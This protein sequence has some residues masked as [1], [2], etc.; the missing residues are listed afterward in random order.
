MNAGR[1]RLRDAVRQLEMGS[2]ANQ[3]KVWVRITSVRWRSSPRPPYVGFEPAASSPKGRIMLLNSSPANASSY[4]PFD[5]AAFSQ[6]SA[7]LLPARPRLRL[8]PESSRPAVQ[9]HPADIVTRRV[10]TTDCMAAEVVQATRREKIEFRFRAPFHLLVIYDQGSRNSGDTYVEGLPRSTLRDLARKLVFVPAGQEYREWQ[11][12][13]VR[14]RVM[15]IYFDPARMPLVDSASASL[16]PRLFFEDATL[17]N[18]ALKLKSEIE[19]G[20][21]DSSSYFDALAGV[22][23]HELLRLDTG[24]ARPRTLD[25]GGLAAW[26]KRTVAAYI[27]EHLA[28]PIPLATL[29]QLAGLSAYHFCRTFKQS[30]GMPPHRYHTS[31]RIEHAKTLLAKSPSTVTD[32]GLSVGFSDTSSFTGVFRK[33]T[34]LTPTAFRRSLE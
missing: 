32:I 19:N 4:D 8:A 20:G 25:H 15:Y 27:E 9:V 18:T 1:P 33:T 12:P 14:A 24:A 6:H 21:P 5:D 28:E 13:R 11:E 22:L 10:V 34:G 31:R 3:T 23:A 2:R 17:W 30:F 29:A 26:Q 16:T 7:A